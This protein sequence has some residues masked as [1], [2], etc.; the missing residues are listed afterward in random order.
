MGPWIWCASSD[1]SY[2]LGYLV[3]ASAYSSIIAQATVRPA[4]TAPV[5]IASTTTSSARTAQSSSSSSSSSTTTS[6]YNV[7]GGLSQVRPADFQRGVCTMAAFTDIALHYGI[8]IG[9]GTVLFPQSACSGTTCNLQASDPKLGF[10]LSGTVDIPAQ[11]ICN[12][13]ARTV[14]G[15]YDIGTAT[16]MG[17]Q[18]SAHYYVSHID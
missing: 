8:C 7:T 2:D 10:G 14:V 11:M 16:S 13:I 9:S 3:S 6:I 4:A 12:G 15:G 18:G 1:S 5:S 17:N